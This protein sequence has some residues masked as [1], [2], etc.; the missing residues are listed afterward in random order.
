VAEQAAH[1]KR[2][3]AEAEAGRAKEEALRKERLQ[4]YGSLVMNTEFGLRDNH[5]DSGKVRGNSF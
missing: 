1:W 5:Q 4:A 3:Q 2:M